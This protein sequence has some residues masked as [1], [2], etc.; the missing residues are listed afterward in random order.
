MRQERGETQQTEFK[1]ILRDSSA[2]KTL[3]GINSI[4]IGNYLLLLNSGIRGHVMRG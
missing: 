1:M 4:E 3:P 2:A